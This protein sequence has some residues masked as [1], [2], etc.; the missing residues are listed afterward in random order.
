M[1]MFFNWKFDS[2]PLHGLFPQRR[3]R[4][5]KRSL[6]GQYQVCSDLHC[7]LDSHCPSANPMSMWV[8]RVMRSSRVGSWPTSSSTSETFPEVGSQW[9]PEYG[10]ASHNSWLWSC[11]V[12]CGRLC[13]EEAADEACPCSLKTHCSVERKL[14]RL[15]IMGSPHFQWEVAHARASPD[16]REVMKAIFSLLEAKTLC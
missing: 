9:R 15:D 1:G 3:Q 11:Y 7:L 16:S 6:E 14:Y 5:L 12:D 2:I 13:S 8:T 4:S 10:T